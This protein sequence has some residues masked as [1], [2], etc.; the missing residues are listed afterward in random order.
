MSRGMESIPAVFVVGLTVTK[1]KVSVQ[2]GQPSSV[3]SSARRP[4]NRILMR[5]PPSQVGYCS[6]SERGGSGVNVEGAVFRSGTMTRLSSGL[7][8]SP[9]QS[10]GG[11]PGNEVRRQQIVK[12]RTKRKRPAPTTNAT[13]QNTIRRV[14]N[15]WKLNLGIFRLTLQCTPDTSPCHFDMLCFPGINF[16]AAI[17]CL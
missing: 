17:T 5:L 2:K 11:I 15:D 13:P 8:R 9:T 10:A 16:T 7:T 3:G 14:E 4:T 12:A 6:S 1:I